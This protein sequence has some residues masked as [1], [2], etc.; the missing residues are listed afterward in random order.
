MERPITKNLLKNRI[1]DQPK[2]GSVKFIMADY[3]RIRLILPVDNL[4][5]EE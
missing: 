5:E 4:V 2:P 3:T 1:L